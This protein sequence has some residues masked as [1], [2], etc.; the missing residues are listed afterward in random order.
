MKFEAILFDVTGTT[1]REKDPNTMLMCFAKAFRDHGFDLDVDFIRK[2]RGNDNKKM[3][4]MI[5]EYFGQSALLVAPIYDS[6]K[7]HLKNS[8]D[9]FEPNEG[10]F[11]LFTFLKSITTKIGLGTGMERELLQALLKKLNWDINFFDYIACGDDF[12]FQRPM[13]DMIIG[14]MQ[15]FGITDGEKVLKV[16][17]TVMDIREGKNAF[18]KTCAVLSGTQS[19]DVI[20][21]EEPDLL[22]ESLV[23]LR[24]YLEDLY[25]GSAR[26]S[27]SLATKRD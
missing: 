1:V 8:L 9:N 24:N 5:L 10:A 17:D 16:G 7:S 12:D 3:I 20:L 19:E 11:E 2:N 14:M 27:V 23:N 22:V 13:P 15:K 25:F 26:P 6:F 18:V 21:N 4:A